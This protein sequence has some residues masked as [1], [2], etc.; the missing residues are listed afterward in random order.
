LRLMVFICVNLRHLRIS[1]APLYLR[2]CAST[3]M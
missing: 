2:I 1:I 3:G